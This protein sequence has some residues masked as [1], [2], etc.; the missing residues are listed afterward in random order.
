M[1]LTDKIADIFNW[2]KKYL[3]EMDHLGLT[4]GSHGKSLDESS[5]DTR[6][7]VGKIIKSCDKNNYFIH[8]TNISDKPLKLIVIGRMYDFNEKDAI[9]LTKDL[10][11]DKDLVL[12]I[13]ENDQILKTKLNCKSVRFNGIRSLPGTSEEDQEIYGP[14]H[15]TYSKEHDY[16]GKIMAAY[17][18]S[19]QFEKVYQHAYPAAAKLCTGRRNKDKI[20]GESVTTYD[21]TLISLAEKEGLSYAVLMPKIVPLFNKERDSPLYIEDYRKTAEVKFSE[22]EDLLEKE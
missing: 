11:T 15:K 14:Y 2:R 3:L 17:C 21:R 4:I 13:R 12:S 6:D 7:F 22:I 19:P 9:S 18:T 1:G 10:S 8:R 20:T 16:M 5:Q